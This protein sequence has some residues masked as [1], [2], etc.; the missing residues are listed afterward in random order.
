MDNSL[1][2]IGVAVKRLAIDRVPFE[3]VG[4]HAVVQGPLLLRDRASFFWLG[5]S[6]VRRRYIRGARKCAFEFIFDR[7]SLFNAKA[8][9]FAL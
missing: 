9:R 3:L 7:F 5:G 6:S 8:H 4:S 2:L 1:S